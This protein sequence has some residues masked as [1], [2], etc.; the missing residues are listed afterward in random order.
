MND[1]LRQHGFTLIELLVAVALISIILSMAY[2]SYVTTT[3]S[4]EACKSRIAL[5][6]KGRKALEQISRHI[7]GS[8]AGAA[9]DND[10]NARN[11]AGSEQS[12][13]EQSINY[14]KGDAG[15][16][17]GEILHLVTT[18]GLS[19]A[20]AA[21]DGLYEISYR[22]N[23]RTSQLAASAARFVGTAQKARKEDWQIVWDEVESV[24]LE[25]FDGEN[26]LRR[27]DFTKKKKLPRAVRIE[28]TGCND[29]RQRYDY[30]TVAY[31]N[32]SRA[33]LPS[34]E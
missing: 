34:Q 21:E 7:R 31:I 3:K 2:G 20:K 10:V 32:V 16:L 28:I 19:E 27:W 12:Q 26:W 6:D 8:Y 14:F 25:F 22:F 13:I 29:S 1:R 11:I 24:D 4:A 18:C 33:F 5:S 23:R 30:G 17:N 9:C 15:G